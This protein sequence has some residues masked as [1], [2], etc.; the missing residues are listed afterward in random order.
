[1]ER[2][3]WAVADADDAERDQAPALS[4]SARWSN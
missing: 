2:L 3:G 1:L 4:Y